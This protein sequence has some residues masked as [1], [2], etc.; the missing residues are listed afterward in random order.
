MIAFND[1][2]LQSE[3]QRHNF[4]AAPTMPKKCGSLWVR[5]STT[6]CNFAPIL[7][8]FVY[9]TDLDPGSSLS[10]DT[11]PKTLARR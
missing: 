3:T 1:F 2:N 9:G 8:F 4:D 5:L 10:E 6:S 11:D 7:E